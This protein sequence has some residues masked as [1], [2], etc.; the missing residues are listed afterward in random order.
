MTDNFITL[1]KIDV[2]QRQLNQAIRL[3]FESGDPVSIRTLTEAAGEVLS[4]LSEYKG[5]LRSRE[6]VH[7]SEYRDWLKKIFAAR[8]FFKHSDRDAE[9]T[10]EFNTVSNEYILIDAILMYFQIM[11]SWTAE[12]KI[13]YM[14]SIQANGEFWEKE[15]ADKIAV[16]KLGL[17]SPTEKEIYLDYIDTLERQM[18]ELQKNR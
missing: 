1:T 9:D 13:F 16:Q 7:P 2:A 3:F 5:V 12:T 4:G 14:W 18:M 11:Q 8:N 17:A 6:S 10:I 15:T